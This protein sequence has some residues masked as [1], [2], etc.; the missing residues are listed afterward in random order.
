MKVAIIGAGSSGLAAVKSCLEEGLD[1]T[2]FERSEDIGGVWRYTK[3]VENGRASIYQ[4]VV[5]NTSKEMMCYSD[6]PIPETYPNYLPNTKLLAYYRAY[7]ERFNLLKYIQFQTLVHSVKKCP[8]FSSS[9]QWEIITEK[10]GK[11]ESAIFDAVMVCSGHHADPYYPVETFPGLKTFKGEYFHSR[12]YK[13]S[14]GFEGKRILIVGMGNSAADIA[15]ELSRAASQVFISTRRGA[16][17]MSRVYDQ[18]YPWDICF[19]TR[20]QNWI[21]NTLPSSIV[22]WL[23][24]RKMNA[25]FDHANYGLQPCDRTQFKEPLFNDELPSRIT[26]G[27]VV[28]KPNVTEFSE[29]TVKFNDGS[30]EENIDVVIFATGYAYAFPFLDESIIKIE[31]SKANLYRSII[32]PNL[33]KP[34]LGIIGLIQPLGPIMPTAE[35]QARWLTRIFKGLCRY[36]PQSEVMDDIA[37]KKEIFVKRFG[38]TREN[39]LQM[40]FIEYLDELASDIGAKPN[41]WKMFLTDPVLAMALFFGPCTPVHYRLIGPGKWSEARRQI[42]TTWDRMLIPTKTR[43]VKNPEAKSVP[44]IHLLGGL[45]L[46]AVLLAVVLYK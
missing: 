34:T 23:T 5:T 16:W 15:V 25:W 41:T 42:L 32:P 28:V 45:C 46:L 6:Y 35:L 22:C 44:F 27:F 17:V 43:I 39:R 24:E 9:G 1:P 7:A 36:P 38:S 21:R 33:E 18:G 4:S 2:C 11:Q 40:D 13:N 10:G 20:L 30:K 14:H 29:T 8:D 37:K 26:C 12:E 19:D 31:T 3:K